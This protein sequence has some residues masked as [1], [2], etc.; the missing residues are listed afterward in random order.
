M[1]RVVK[2]L[3]LAAACILALGGPAAAGVPKV[4]IAENYGATW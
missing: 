4:V 3:M 2:A 1:N